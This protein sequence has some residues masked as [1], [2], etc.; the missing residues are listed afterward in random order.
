MVFSTILSAA[1]APLHLVV[2]ECPPLFHSTLIR[3]AARDLTDRSLRDFRV[4]AVIT[5][6]GL[7]LRIPLRNPATSRTQCH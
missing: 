3:L 6:F 7:L 2:D 1:R 5:F 4:A